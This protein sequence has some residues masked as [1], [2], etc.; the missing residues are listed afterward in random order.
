MVCWLRNTLSPYLETKSA[1]LWRRKAT[2]AECH[3]VKPSGKIK[4]IKNIQPRLLVF[5]NC[6]PHEH[7]NKIPQ[8]M[9][10][11]NSQSA[12]WSFF[13][14]LFQGSIIIY[15]SY[16]LSA[17]SPLPLTKVT[18][19]LIYNNQYLIRIIHPLWQTNQCM[20]FRPTPTSERTVRACSNS[21]PKRGP[22]FEGQL[23]GLTF[24]SLLH[25]NE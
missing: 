7:V 11:F 8:W 22:C 19:V 15:T 2:N 6:V 16:N 13:S 25:G 4:K 23:P 14:A 10:S 5:S 21:M 9:M 12:K 20:F 17:G 3:S 1:S 18:Y 24:S